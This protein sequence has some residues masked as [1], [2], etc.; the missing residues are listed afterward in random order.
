MRTVNSMRNIIYAISGQS[1]SI[2]INF[3]S[4]SIF[5][6]ILGEYFLGLNGL[7][8]NVISVLSL[9]EMGIGSAIIYGL[10]EPLVNGDNRK[11]SKLVRFYKKAYKKIGI[12]VSVMGLLLVPLLKYIVKDTN[13]LNENYI[14]IIF[15][16]FLI[17]TVITY[18]YSYK[19]TLLIADQKAYVDTLYKYSFFIV[20]NIIQ[21]IILVLT[22]NY[23][24][25]LIAQI[26]ITF[27]ENYRVARKVNEIY[28]WLELEKEELEREEK[29]KLVKN[30]KALLLHKIGGVLVLSTDNIIISSFV[31]I[32]WVGIYSNYLL[33]TSAI[34]SIIGQV[35]VALTGSVGNLTNSESKEK[36]YEIYKVINLINYWIV[37]VCSICVYININDFINIWIGEEFILSSYIVL[38]ICANFYITGM[39]KAVSVYKDTYGLF[40]QDRYKAIVEGILNI[41]IS[42]V[43]AI[44]LGLSGVLLGT[45]ISSILTCFWIEPYVLFKYGF[46]IKL[47]NYMKKYLMNLVLAIIVGGVSYFLCSFIV[48]DSWWKLIF[49]AG[50]SFIV[51]NIS[52]VLVYFNTKEFRYIRGIVKGLINREK[53]KGKIVNE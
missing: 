17:N 23:I 24:L 49:K 48:V 4:R 32:I 19:R 34:N 33:V 41:I 16:L 22:K 30:V 15:I 27:V 35:F 50:I 37:A 21:I 1:I 9:A 14:R 39:R 46:K 5:I 44:K 42:V 25:Y 6:K 3:I 45:L 20:L 7:F 13:G 47:K 43:L 36:A 8:L 51:V 31:G 38:I 18:F 53:V 40:Y 12:I 2:I 10:Y 26:C 52:I 11:V 28:P 29:N